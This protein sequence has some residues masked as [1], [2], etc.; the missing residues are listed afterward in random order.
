MGSSTCE[1]GVVAASGDLS[2]WSSC[3]G[4]ESRLWPDQASRAWG[5]PRGVGV[6]LF[7]G[8]EGL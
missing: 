8:T 6:L 2:E 1:G 3:S 5:G 4:P 7:E